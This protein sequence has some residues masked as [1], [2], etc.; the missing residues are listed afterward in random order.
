MLITRLYRG[1]RLVA[2]SESR[3]FLHWEAPQV[4]LQATPAEGTARQTYC[5]PSF[6]YA[7]VYLGYVMMYNATGDRTVD[8]ELAW[9]PDAVRW[10]RVCPASR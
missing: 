7:N 9:S 4:V 2:R 3:D 6:P 1:E 5:M 10:Q 8:C